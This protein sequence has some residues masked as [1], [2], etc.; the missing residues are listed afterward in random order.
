MIEGINLLVG[1]VVKDNLEEK[2]MKLTRKRREGYPSDKRSYFLGSNYVVSVVEEL[3]SK[4]DIVEKHKKSIYEIYNPTVLTPF[5]NKTYSDLGK[6][7]VEKD[8]D[9]ERLFE[10]YYNLSKEYGTELTDIDYESFMRGVQPVV[11]LLLYGYKHEKAMKYRNIINL[12]V[13][14]HVDKLFS[15]LKS[16]R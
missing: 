6:D 9:I 3:Y 14:S 8:V 5:L 4:L 1:L 2:L 7:I 16:I 11:D 10:A 15:F 12:A 13:K